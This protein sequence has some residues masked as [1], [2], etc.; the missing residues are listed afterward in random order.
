MY[1]QNSVLL[2]LIIE[3]PKLNHN[4]FETLK[5]E[6]PPIYLAIQKYNERYNESKKT[7]QQNNITNEVY[8]LKINELNYNGRQELIRN[9]LDRLNISINKKDIEDRKK[10][11]RYNDTHPTKR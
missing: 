3:H 8:D 11:P 10:T 9:L 4:P 1:V 5:G 2:Q 6:E 7:L